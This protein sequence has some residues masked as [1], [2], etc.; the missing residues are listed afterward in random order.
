[1]MPF[2]Y[3][4]EKKVLQLQTDARLGGFSEVTF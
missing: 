4:A 1:M 2:S 3:G